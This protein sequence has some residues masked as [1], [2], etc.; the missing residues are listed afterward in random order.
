M[1]RTIAAAVAIY[2]HLHPTSRICTPYRYEI[3]TGR[4][5]RRDCV[6]CGHAGI[7]WCNAYRRTVRSYADEIEHTGP[8]AAQYV[9]EHALAAI[10]L[11]YGDLVGLSPD[12]ASIVRDAIA[13][14]RT[15]DAR[16]IARQE[17]QS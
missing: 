14:G 11:G 8:C 2:R 3:N 4:R 13:L 16:Q 15:S 7:S 5:A 6:L 9:R 1:S 12:V 10:T 17:T